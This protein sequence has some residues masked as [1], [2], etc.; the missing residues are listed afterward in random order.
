MNLKVFLMKRFT[1]KHF[2]LIL[3]LL[4]SIN[5]FSQKY[6]IKVTVTNCVSPHLTLISL[7]SNSVVFEE[8]Y[9]Y[10]GEKDWEALE[11]NRSFLIA[12]PSGNY[13]LCVSNGFWFRPTFIEVNLQDRAL[14]L[15]EIEVEEY[16]PGPPVKTKGVIL[17]SGTGHMHEWGNS[18]IIKNVDKEKVSTQYI[19]SPYGK[20][21]NFLDTLTRVL[22]DF[23]V[24]RDVKRIPTFLLD[25]VP[26]EMNILE[27]INLFKNMPAQN[28][29]YFTKT[30]P[31]ESYSG[32]LV[33][34]VTEASYEE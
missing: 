32:G 27:L 23:R 9:S 16:P 22:S 7:D 17:L 33:E 24:T 15:G 4:L 28:I 30:M 34:I 14:N 29:I 19:L 21:S 31:S 2:L 18:F 13:A 8:S 25:N 12:V 6:G 5:L 10:K 1:L 26:L 11:E 20:R 3:G